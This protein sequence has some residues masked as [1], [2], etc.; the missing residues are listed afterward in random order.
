MKAKH[1]L[2]LILFSPA[3]IYQAHAQKTAAISDSL[4]CDN[5]N[6]VL[7]CASIDE[8]TT[9]MA[10]GV[11]D[12]TYIAGVTP[13]LRLT[14]TQNEMIMKEYGK[15]SYIGYLYSSRVSD[16]T[17]IQKYTWWYKKLKDCLPL[18]DDALLKSATPYSPTQPDD[19]FFTNT[20]DETSVRLSIV[21]DNGYHVKLWI[22]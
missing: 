13:D 21:K 11:K 9:R 20:E 6:E 14:D 15:V 10:Q 4:W 7:K 22:F 8:I 17:L 5:L 18:W 19:Y 2:L 16:S 1:F 12:S 3:F